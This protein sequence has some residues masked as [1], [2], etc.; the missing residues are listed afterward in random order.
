MI[1][2]VHRSPFNTGLIDGSLQRTEHNNKY[3]KEEL[4][5][6][7]NGDPDEILGC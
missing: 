6:H 2:K 1:E 7:H 5:R 3:T 4:K